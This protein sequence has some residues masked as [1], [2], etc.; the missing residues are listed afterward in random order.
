MSNNYTQF[1]TAVIIPPDKVEF[2]MAA[3]LAA[4]REFLVEGRVRGNYLEDTELVLVDNEYRAHLG[5]TEIVSEPGQ[6]WI[7]GEESGD[8]EVAICAIETIQTVLQL[9]TPHV[10]SWAYTCSKPRLD[11]FGGGA[12]QCRRGHITE[13]IDAYQAARNLELKKVEK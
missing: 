4:L 7:Y 8:I 9:D 12:V 13:T 6:I 3:I 11:E 1:S 5:G 10:F 2:V